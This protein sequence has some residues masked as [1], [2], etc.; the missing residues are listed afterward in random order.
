MQIN[1]TAYRVFCY[2]YEV[3][4]ISQHCQI[5]EKLLTTTAVFMVGNVLNYGSC[6]CTSIFVHTDNDFIS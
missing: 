2:V 3:G 6:N 4:F 5:H 1:Y